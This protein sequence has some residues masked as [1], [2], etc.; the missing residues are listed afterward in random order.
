MFFSLNKRFFFTIITFLLLC[1]GIFF[2]IFE[3]TIGKKLQA[4]Q[5]NIITRNQYVIELLNENIA[6]RKKISNLQPDIPLQLNA[7]QEELKLMLHLMKPKYF[8]P[9]HGEYRMLK[10]HTELAQEVGVKKENTFGL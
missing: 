8:M 9:M 3:K 1:S 2:I 10:L 5:S 6:L 7:K 4:E